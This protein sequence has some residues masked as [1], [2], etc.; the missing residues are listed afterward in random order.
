MLEQGHLR[1][2]A[3]LLEEQLLLPGGILRAEELLLPFGLLGTQEMLAGRVALGNE[4]GGGGTR[5]LGTLESVAAGGLPG[6]R[7]AL[8]LSCCGEHLLLALLAGR[9]VFQLPMGI[10]RRALGEQAMRGLRGLH[11][12][13]VVT[14]G[15]GGAHQQPVPCEAGG[16]G[17]EQMAAGR[18]GANFTQLLAAALSRPAQE[19]VLARGC[20]A[21]EQEVLPGS[22]GVREQEV[23]P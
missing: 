19:Q 11:A 9:L 3:R 22:G 12:L 21:G 18:D 17:H 10:G 23:M 8:L 5:V 1:F 14:V 13:Q 20:S 16:L 2:L 6:G 7:G 15:C 4:C